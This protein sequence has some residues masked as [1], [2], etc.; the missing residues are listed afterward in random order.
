MKRWLV[1]P[2]LFLSLTAL[3]GSFSQTYR[4]VL[5]PTRIFITSCFPCAVFWGNRQIAILQRGTRAR[6]LGSTKQWILIRFWDGEKY[7]VGWIKR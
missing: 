5:D 2:A 6:I 3:P 4:P 1:F 7:V